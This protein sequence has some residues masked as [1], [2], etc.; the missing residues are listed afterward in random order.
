MAF[1][2]QKVL[3]SVPQIVLYIGFTVFCDLGGK[4][5]LLQNILKRVC[6]GPNGC[7]FIKK[8]LWMVRPTVLYTYLPVSS[9]G[10]SCVNCW[11][12]S[13]LQIQSAEKDPSCQ[14]CW[15]ILWAYFEKHTRFII[16][17]LKMWTIR[18]AQHSRSKQQGSETVSW[19]PPSME[20]TAPAP[21]EE[22]ARRVAMVKAWLFELLSIVLIMVNAR[23]RCMTRSEAWQ[24]RWTQSSATWRKRW[25]WTGCC[26]RKRRAAFLIVE[27]CCLSWALCDVNYLFRCFYFLPATSTA[28]WTSSRMSC[29]EVVWKGNLIARPGN[30]LLELQTVW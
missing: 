19:K 14:R 27:R 29:P 18:C 28:S 10:Q 13:P 22:C 23:R 1:A 6:G 9:W 5:L 3:W 17:G 30:S 15:G 8:N 26:P 7:C 11:R 21:L 25:V 20:T 16:V 12:V 2:S 24:Y 4:W